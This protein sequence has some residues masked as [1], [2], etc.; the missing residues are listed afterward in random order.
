MIYNSPNKH[1]F[2]IGCT[3][4][5]YFSITFNTNFVSFNNHLSRLES[6]R[7]E[8]TFL[9]HDRSPKKETDTQPQRLA[10]LVVL[11]L[12][13]SCYLVLSALG[14]V[15]LFLLLSKVCSLLNWVMLL[16]WLL[17][18]LCWMTAVSAAADADCCAVDPP[19]MS[20]LLGNAQH[21]LHPSSQYIRWVN[22]PNLTFTTYKTHAA[23]YIHIYIYLLT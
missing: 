4:H 11:R 21:G 16:V 7:C 8:D 19:W 22:N 15:F 2:S 5:I 1:I 3:K 13:F 12:Y 6:T 9:S 18:W 14:F 10:F 23:S 20:V 17:L